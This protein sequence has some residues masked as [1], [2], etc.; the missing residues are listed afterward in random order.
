MDIENG[1]NPKEEEHN[2][3]YR[4]VIFVTEGILKIFFLVF[5]KLSLLGAR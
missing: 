1:E 4:G 5:L 2:L 3:L